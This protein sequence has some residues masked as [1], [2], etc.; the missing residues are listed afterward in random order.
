ESPPVGFTFIGI[1][2]NQFGFGDTL[3]FPTP[4]AIS[5]LDLETHPYT[6]LFENGSGALLL[7][8]RDHP[9]YVELC[10]VEDPAFCETDADLANGVALPIAPLLDSFAPNDHSLFDPNLQPY[11]APTGDSIDLGLELPFGG[12]YS[13]ITPQIEER[14]EGY[15]REFLDVQKTSEDAI[16]SNEDPASDSNRYQGVD[17][18]GP[19]FPTPGA[20][21]YTTDSA[22]L[23]VLV[24][25]LDVYDVL[26]GTTAR[27]SPE[28]ANVGGDFGM[29]FSTTSYEMLDAPN[30]SVAGVTSVSRAKGQVLVYPEFEVSVSAT[31]APGE[32]AIVATFVNA[33]P[34][35]VGDPPLANA[36][37]F[38]INPVRAVN[39]TTGQDAQGAPFQATSL[40]AVVGLPDDPSVQNEFAASEIGQYIAATAGVSSFGSEGNLSTLLDPDTDLSSAAVVDPLIAKLPSEIDYIEEA[41][42]SGRKS[43]V[44]T[45]QTSA[46]VLAGSTTYADSFNG[47]GDRLNARRF[48]NDSVW[49]FTR[50]SGHPAYAPNGEVNYV[51]PGGRVDQGNGF[52]KVTTSRNFELAILDTNLDGSLLESGSKD[53]FGIILKVASVRADSPV[54]PGEF[55]F[56]SMMGG[57]EGADIDTLNIP[58]PEE[59]TLMSV[60]LIDLDPLDT[61]LGVETISD[62]YLVDANGESRVDPLE[63]FYLSVPEPSATLGLSVGLVSVAC[64]AHRRRRRGAQVS[65]RSRVG[66]PE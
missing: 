43:L 54:E 61:E 19:F 56:L 14:G 33:I 48:T 39:P 50:T 66:G 47:A 28:A 29:S 13:A 65:S 58:P 10:S 45:V 4:V 37:A 15:A 34:A 18:H 23:S 51:S 22:S 2:G 38:G 40:I 59:A 49:G 9:R 8:D 35:E 16:A 63:V 41:G 12:V 21:T 57:R 36:H 55:V 3:N 64:L 26:T 27:P 62:V 1:N 6:G 30:I 25:S 42:P 11:D 24:E 44:E 31:A 17:A 32:T 53:D 46:E 52:W 5:H 20:A 7:M 60:I